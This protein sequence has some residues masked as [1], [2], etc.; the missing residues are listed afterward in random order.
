VQWFQMCRMV[1]PKVFIIILNWNGL[2]DTLECLESVYKLDYP[3]FEVIVVDN[4]SADNSLTVI[5][6]NYRQVMMIESKEN[7]GYTGGNNVGMSYAM[8]NGADYMWLLNN[9]TIVEA[10]TLSKLVSTAESSPEVGIISPII[11]YYDQPD[12]IQFWGD[13]L[14]WKK[15]EVLKVENLESW[16]DI[17]EMHGKTISLWGTALLI[18]RDIIEKLGY[19][20]SKYFAYHE[21]CEYSI[22][23]A[24]AGYKCIIEP[25]AKLYH[26]DSR[27]TGSRKTPFQVYFRVRNYYF[28]WMENVEGLTRLTYFRKFL[29][30][31]ISYA[32]FLMGEKLDESA[33]AC[34][35]GAWCAIRN[36]GGPWSGKIKMPY[37]MKKIFSWHPYFWANLIRGK[38]MNVAF[39]ILKRAK[40][41]V[42][43]IIA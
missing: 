17:N 9:D 25:E 1:C 29:A 28:L 5:R 39:E 14:D 22:R 6:E 20:N 23:V 13:Y 35:D 16:D 12:K 3:N 4:G 19:L 18:K 26:K 2:K 33:D 36:I 38:F 37:L 8:Q 34:F 32:G 24:K 21:D 40:I 42:L 27:S 10:D 31:S 30:E 7:L 11:Y 15:F 41:R 43:K